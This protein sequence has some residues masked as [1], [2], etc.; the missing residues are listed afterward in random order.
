LVKRYADLN[1]LAEYVGMTVNWVYR[2]SNQFHAA[3]VKLNGKI[4]RPLRFDLDVVDSIYSCA[5]C[6][7][8]TEGNG[9]LPL[10]KVGR[11]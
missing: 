3:K 2:N 10:R 7:L 9:V 4:V 6:S 11:L 1:E 8:K 5:A